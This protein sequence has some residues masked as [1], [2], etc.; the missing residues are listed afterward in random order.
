MRNNRK[1]Y[2]LRAITCILLCLCM[3]LASAS[4][5]SCNKNNDGLDGEGLVEV[6][7][8]IDDINEGGK[9]TSDR[10]ATV[11]VS[12]L[13]VPEGALSDIPKSKYAAV[14]LYPGDYITEEKLTDV[15]PNTEDDKKEDVVEIAPELLGYVVITSYSEHAQGGDYT[16][17]IDKAIEENPGRTIYF[18]DGT[19]IIRKPIDIPADPEKSVS[20]R[21]SN[22][23]VI[24][25]FDWQDPKTAMIRIGANASDDAQSANEGTVSVDEYIRTRASC[26]VIGGC[27]NAGALASGISIEDGRDAL[28]YNV[29]IKNAF[30]GIHIKEGKNN[31]GAGFANI[32]NV[33]VTGFE[34]A[35]SVGVLVEGKYN[36]VSNMRI[37]SVQYGVKCTETGSNNIFRNLHPLGVSMNA[38]T[39]T[40]GFWDMSDGNIF[41]ICYSDQFAT[42]FL[43]EENTRS[44][45]T[46]CFCYWWT[47]AGGYHVG[48]RSNGKF[49]SIVTNCK[50]SHSHQ[51]I[52]TDAYLLVGED[53]GQGVVLYPA[54][55]VANHENDYILEQYCPTG[56]L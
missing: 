12:A 14:K 35:D 44:V 45:F 50:V 47:A 40:A 33:N 39:T 18:P 23:T 26:Y 28:I 48:F 5:T 49:N 29:S 15:K 22:N 38:S 43:V 4:L 27:L 8:V 41:D 3:L 25:A 6:I 13:S 1:K 16:D 42:G 21:L 52:E 20:L 54:N 7:R 11:K 32:D 37:A 10:I 51:G 24:K 53:G 56:Q 55:N 17:A 31:A 34:A 9:I 46:G 19:Y 2:R 30:Y 36:N